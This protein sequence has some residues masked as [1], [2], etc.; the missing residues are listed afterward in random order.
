[1]TL[2]KYINLR[3]FQIHLSAD[4]MAVRET[5]MVTR[6]HWLG[7][8]L[9]EDTAELVE[10]VLAEA[11][12]NVVEHAQMDRPDGSVELAIQQ[13]DTGLNCVI[14]DDGAPMPDGKLPD[15]KLA[16]VPLDIQDL[17]EGG[18]G[19]FL[20]RTL[21]RDLEYTRISGWNFLSFEIPSSSW[22]NIEAAQRA[23]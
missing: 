23:S 20:I 10:Q 7:A 2:M 14:R 15:G 16:D 8:G 4:P 21:A 22:E 17:P 6:D 18:F 19:W 5:I 13:T 9:T 3:P 12:N 11:L 1:M